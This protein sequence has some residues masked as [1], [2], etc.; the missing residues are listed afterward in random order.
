MLTLGLEQVVTVFDG[1]L[2]FEWYYNMVLSSDLVEC[3]I[4]TQSV[5]V[6]GPVFFVLLN[7]NCKQHLH[8]RV[9]SLE[10]VDSLIFCLYFNI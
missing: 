7:F 6:L 2:I 3:N 9:P 5:F 10:S 1:V 8:I 4:A